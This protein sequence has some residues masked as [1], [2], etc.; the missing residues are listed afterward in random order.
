MPDGSTTTPDG[1]TP[2]PDGMAPDP[3]GGMGGDG[4]GDQTCDEYARLECARNRDCFPVFLDW[5]YGSYDA[6]LTQAKQICQVWSSLAG[7]S[8][9]SAKLVGCLRAHAAAGCASPEPTGDCVT[10]PGQLANDGACHLNDQCASGYCRRDGTSDCGACADK[11][12]EGA[13]CARSSECLSGRCSNN[14]CEPILKEG[15]ACV[16]TNDCLRNLVCLGGLCEKVTLVGEGEA[17]GWVVF[18][19]PYLT[20]A[21]GICVKDR[22]VDTGQRCG[23]QDDGAFALCRNGD[24]NAESICVTRPALGAA[25]SPEGS[26]AGTGVCV[27]GQCRELAPAVCG[28]PRQAILR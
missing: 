4:P 12:P 19:N 25:C 13:K 2:D 26:C 21:N 3:D 11:L 28:T 17:C 6:C 22:V 10:L 18:C 9:T 27:Q 23:T 14:T 1:G 15:Q 5:T 8:V 16:E 20:C 24:C 7:T